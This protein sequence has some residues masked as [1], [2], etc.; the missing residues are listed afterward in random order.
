MAFGLSA[1]AVSLIGAGVGAAGSYL[2]SKNAPKNATSTMQQQIDPRMDAM[3]WGKDGSTGLLDQYKSM[4]PQSAG[5]QTYQNAG[6][7]YLSNY[8]GANLESIRSAADGLMWGD[9]APKTGAAVASLPA[10]AAG[11]MVNAPSQNG[12]DLAGSY[13]RF[14][15]GTPGANPYLDQSINGAIAQNRLGFQQLQDDS[16]RN[17]MQN[18]L[19]S[20]RSNSVLSGQY[21]GSRQG[22]AE[23]NAI[24]MNQLEQQRAAAQFGQNATNAAVGAKA[25]AYETDSNRALSATQGLG[26]QQYGVA[27]QDANT[28]NQAEFMN[29]GNSF[30]ASKTN[31]GLF[32]QSNLA[33]QQ[34]QL[35]TNA[36]NNSAAMG[37]AGL[38]GG[39]LSS[40]TG[41][42]NSDLTRA[43][44][45]NNLL[46]PYLDANMS[47]T[48]TQP[49][50]Q[51][52]GG[53][54]LG[55]ALMGG[56]LG[57]MFSSA[58][59]SPN[60]TDIRNVDNYGTNVGNSGVFGNTSPKFDY[61]P[62]AINTPN[63]GGLGFLNGI[64]G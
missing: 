7:D 24:G 25:N 58:F 52:T 36:Q 63:V 12:V 5:M 18:I 10:Y 17:L 16:N 47:K 20:I 27:S 42:A 39:V 43:T 38:L 8:G 44:G 19:P 62:T 57:N 11:N 15:N 14:V 50:Y 2:S 48:A 45:V 60:Y 22:I 13:D 61:T 56:Q 23:G 29:V 55:G 53:N 6:S 54:I 41:S 46:A 3:L 31:A 59:G 9:S 28:K 26:A 34:A 4:L 35:A 33:N 21:G 32:Q 51:N 64:G 1:G 40:A 37:G 30:D 49:L